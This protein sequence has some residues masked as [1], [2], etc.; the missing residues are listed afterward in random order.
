M[1]SEMILQKICRELVSVHAAHTILLYGSRADDSS[2]SDSD[3]DIASFGLIDKAFRIARVD[4]GAYLDVFV[5]P[6]ALLFS[7]NEEHLKLRGS[8]ILLQRDSEAT[9][10]LTKLDEIFRAGPKALPADEIN[11]LKVWAHKMVAR[12]ARPDAEGK[13]RRV[14][15]LTEL[16]ED[17]FYIRG[18]WFEG[19]KKALRWLAEFDVPAHDAMLLALAPEA[20]AEAISRLVHLVVGKLEAWPH[21]PSQ[22]SQ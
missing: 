16:L 9:D 11:V 5:Y 10:F 20:S 22:P 8:R 2:T 21:D 7:P 19:P 14:W 17:Y 15:L 3:Y 4:E 6:E 18:L 13:Y 1:R 12:I